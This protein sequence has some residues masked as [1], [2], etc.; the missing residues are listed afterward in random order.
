MGEDDLDKLADRVVDKMAER[1]HVCSFTSDERADIH[2]YSRAKREAKAGHGD[3]VNAL[4]IGKSLNGWH[5]KSLNLG[6]LLLMLL[7]I[8][9]TLKSTGVLGLVLKLL[10][11]K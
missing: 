2:E 10:G 4:L 9:I 1:G 6:G 5:V 3:I 7:L 8:W 11:G